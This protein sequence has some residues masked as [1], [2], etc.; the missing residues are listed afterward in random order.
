VTLRYLLDTNI[1][2][3]PVAKKPDANVVKRLTRHG[4]TCAISAPVWHELTYGCHR[5]PA[6]RRRLAL[7]AYIEDVIRRSFPILPYDETAAMWHGHER[8]RLEALG[9]PAPYVDGQIAAIAH[10]HDLV[11][12]T[13]NTKD[14]ARF[15]GLKLDDWTRGVRRRN[16]RGVIVP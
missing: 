5:L 11:L 7:E 12:V 16:D 3:A 10:V 9:Q 1:A 15:K 8:A 4:A 13:A 2:S 14:F 6:G